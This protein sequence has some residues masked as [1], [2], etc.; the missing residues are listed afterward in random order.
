MRNPPSTAESATL[1]MLQKRIDPNGI[2]VERMRMEEGWIK[3]IA[4]FSGQ[5]CFY[6][7]DGRIWDASGT[8]P[9]HKVIYQVNLVRSAV[10]RA[11]AKVVNVNA[12]FKAVPKSASIRHRNIAEVSDKV[13]DHIRR[14]NDWQHRLH[15]IG[16]QWAALC[17][18]GFYRISFDPLA[19]EPDRF[20]LDSAQTKNV[21]PEALLSDADIRQKERDGLFEDL[22]AGDVRISVENPFAVY[23]D[24]T[25]RDRS[26]EG[27]QWIGFKHYMDRSVLG[28]RYNIDPDDI[29]PT[30]GGPGLNNYEEAIAFFGQSMGGSPFNWFTPE[31]K[32]GERA[33]HIE[34]WQRPSRE[35]KKGRRV[36]SVGGRIVVDGDNPHVG[37]RSTAAH[38]PVVKQDWTP[39]PGRFWGSS[40]V[41]DLT[42]PQNNL[43]ESRACLLEYLRVFGRPPT[44]IDSGS[45]LDVKNMT[46]DP[47]G[48]YEISP[49]SRP[50][51]YSV[52]PQLPPEVTNVGTLCQ[53]DL[54]SVASQSD[55]DGTKLPGQMRSGAAIQQ[56]TQVR[57]LA[58]T[59]SSIEAVRSTR[60]IGRIA[61][62]LGQLFYTEKRTARFLDI[63]GQ[64]EW[65]DFSGADLTNDLVILGQPGQMETSQSRRQEMLDAIQI[66]AINPQE[67][68][69]DRELVLASMHYNEGGILINSKL[70]ARKN[71]EREIREMIA[72]TAKYVPGGYPI[73]D[74]EDHATE[75]SVLVD[76]MYSAAFKTLDVVTKSLIAQHAA[77][78]KQALMKEQMQQLQMQAQM[79]GSPGQKGRASQPAA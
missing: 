77:L 13:F 60:D 41:E 5:Q 12:E 2:R 17:G 68:P 75:L 24:W 18:S 59:V 70:K 32:R 43:N 20:Y 1:E 48:V 64:W 55:V 71:Q 72:N 23:H 34:M 44:F 52:S 35:F 29:Q 15:L 33:L 6:Q 21:V 22:A 31:D 61:L 69:Q 27:C 8:I 79:K 7:A 47:G 73:A 25:S 66:G 39:H 11:V 37:D 63:D 10:I 51:M 30:E 58:L 3:N 50:P 28:D 14:I 49:M 76:F 54:L 45:G 74:Y 26:I 46:I 38:L 67:N 78:H 4:Y 56:M 9:E 53:Q 62:A 16:T 42:S 57:D 36:V 65:M 19:G 40:L